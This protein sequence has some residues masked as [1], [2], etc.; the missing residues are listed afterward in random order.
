VGLR[1]LAREAKRELLDPAKRHLAVRLCLPPLA[2]LVLYL[3][4]RSL[5]LPTGLAG[6]RYL[7]TNPL[8]CFV[9]AM[10]WTLKGVPWE[11]PA[12]ARFALFAVVG[13]AIFVRPAPRIAA[14]MLFGVA[15]M[16]AACLPL[17][18]LGLVEPRLLYLPE[19]G[20]AILVIAAVWALWRAWA[21]RER[22]GLRWAAASAGLLSC[23]ALGAATTHSLKLA[24]DEFRPMSY[25]MLRGYRL[26]VDG[27]KRH[28]YP[29]H[30]VANIERILATA[31]QQGLDGA[32]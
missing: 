13:L 18:R 1:E 31:R 5:V 2:L 32:R 14:A 25:K 9:D 19:V 30:H 23:L 15:T 8:R 11:V 16:V 21:Q 28:L 6:A 7:E 12:P 24:Q 17:A 26:V 4:Y 3:G 29:Q 10:L 27:P 20:H 22:R